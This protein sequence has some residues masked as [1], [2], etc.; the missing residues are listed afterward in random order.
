MTS[1]DLPEP[2]T[3]VTPMNVPSGNATSTLLRLFS[4]A[5][6]TTIAS[7]LPGRRSAGIGIMLRAGQVLRRSASRG[8]AITSAG[9]PS[10][11]T[12]PP[13]SPAPGP[14]SMSQ[15][16]ARIIAS[17]C[18]TTSTVL[19]RSRSRVE[20][21]DQALVVDRVQ[22]DRGLVADVEHAHQRRAD[23]RREP[24]ALPLAAG[25]RRRRA[26]E[27][28]VVEADVAQERQAPRDLLQDLVARSGW[29]RA[30]SG[31][32]SPWRLAAVRVQ[33]E[34]VESLPSARCRRCCGPSMV[35]AR[36]SGFRR[37]P[38]HSGHGTATM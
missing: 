33:L 1:D 7:P 29:S 18:S 28:E 38:P 2:D 25:E 4:V 3:P 5:P 16:A 34:A 17:S 21:A 36:I 32:P 9:V 30:E 10:A 35:T 23:L 11:T 26:V 19:P 27:R 12:S 20:R 37:A 31:E 15:S 22:A 24:D 8:C 13:C 14:M 6:R